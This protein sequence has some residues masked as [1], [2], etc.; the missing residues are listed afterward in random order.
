VSRHSYKGL[1]ALPA[2]YLMDGERLVAS[3]RAETGEAARVEFKKAGLRGTSVRAAS[4]H[5]RSRSRP[6]SSLPSSR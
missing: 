6:G 2:W 4:A 5:L 1:M 3:I